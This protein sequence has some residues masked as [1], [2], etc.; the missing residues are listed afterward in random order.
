[1]LGRTQSEAYHSFIEPIQSAL[2]TISVGR[3]LLA[4]KHGSIDAGV[5]L[6]VTLNGGSNTPLRRTGRGQLLLEVALRVRIDALTFGTRRYQCTLNGYWYTLAEDQGQEVVTYHWTPEAR[7]LERPFPHV[8]IGRAISGKTTDH[9][10][11]THKLHLPS[12]IVSVQHFVRFAIQDL[13]VRVHPN[14]RR[15]HVLS[16]LNDAIGDA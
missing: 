13:G 5:P 12:G 10:E 3:L 1:M 7:G 16:Q 4:R 8:H 6:I 9:W 11:D 2:N 14:L 15:D